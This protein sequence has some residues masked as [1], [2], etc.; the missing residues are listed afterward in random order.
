MALILRFLV[1]ALVGM[2]AKSVQSSP[3]A[4]RM[5]RLSWSDKAKLA[6]A[7]RYDNR[8]PPA[9]RAIAWLPAVYLMLPID[10]VP[11]FIPFIGKMDDSLVFSVASAALQRLAPEEVIIEH[12]ESLHDR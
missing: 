9:G 12:L 1:V 4:K 2:V 5:E 7:L 6:E 11:D 3:V 8:V 10:I